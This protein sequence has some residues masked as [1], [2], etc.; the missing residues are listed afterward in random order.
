MNAV[1]YHSSDYVM[2]LCTLCSSYI[3]HLFSVSD[4]P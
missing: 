2:T 1:P 4:D 3:I